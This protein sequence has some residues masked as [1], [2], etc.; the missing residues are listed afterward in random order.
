MTN[1]N[2]RLDEIL[3][4]LAHQAYLTAHAPGYTKL[5]GRTYKT[6]VDEAKQAINSLFKELVA[7]AKP[8]DY[9][10]EGHEPDA[11]LNHEK[12]TSACCGCQR[13]RARLEAVSEF[14][15]NLLKALEE[16]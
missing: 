4:S 12:Y 9:V 13:Q 10:P 5:D 2:E 15:Q 7:E 8:F 11:C 16:V 14:E 1:Y 6:A 3:R